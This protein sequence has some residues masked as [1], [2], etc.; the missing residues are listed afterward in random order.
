MTTGKHIADGDHSS[1]KPDGAGSVPHA[2]ALGY[3]ARVFL[4]MHAQLEEE[5]LNREVCHPIRRRFWGLLPCRIYDPR[6]G[7]QLL[8]QY[9]H[10][11]EQELARILEKHSVAYWLHLYRR[12]APEPIGADKQP[13]TVGL[14]RATLEAAVQKY[15]RFEPCDAVGVTGD[16]SIG[17]VLGG[18]L[19]EPQFR[20]ERELLERGR[21]L[22]LTKFAT[23]DLREF[24]DAERLAYE[25]WR[26][27]AMLR[28]V[29]KGAAIAVTDS[30]DRVI[31]LRSPEL[32]RLVRV[33]D[34]R[35]GRWQRPTASATGVVF[36][37]IAMSDDKPGIEFLPTYNL[38]RI[39]LSEYEGLFRKLCGLTIT[40][41]A[42]SNFIWFP[43]N[44]REYRDAHAAFSEAFTH[45]HRVDLDLL[46]MILTALCQR[47]WFAWRHTETRLLR[48]EAVLRRWQRAYDG[49]YT[50][51]FIR[52]EI[53][54][55]IPVAAQRLGYREGQINQ[56]QLDAAFGFLELDHAKRQYIDL[57]YP[58]PHHSF[59]PY[60]SEHLFLDYAWIDRRLYDLFLGVQVD[61][62]NFKGDTLERVVR[63]GTSVLPKRACTARD[64]GSRQ[65]DASFAL[66]NRLVI[67]ECRVVWRSVAFDRGDPRAI[68]YRNKMIDKLLADVDAKAH[69]LATRPVG[70]NYDISRFVD[71]L[72]VGVTPFAEYIPS[73]DPRYWLND[74]LPR[75]LTPSELK[76]ALEDGTLAGA[77]T[78]V[79]ATRQAT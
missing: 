26:S 28:I 69:W 77:S 30:D 27:S 68:G 38:G 45:K 49:P 36:D 58:G 41:P 48:A 24:Y 75:V 61:D 44:L 12:L 64:G 67:V 62:Q 17:E 21:Q 33:Y 3:Y 25:V 55:F 76:L 5:G 39:A 70:T 7:R 1:E 43:F 56:D 79:V 72:P 46:V 60:G 2:L 22:V 37:P 11:V 73:L 14:V 51:E 19:M 6:E 15:A 78:N 47:V 20:A 32:N 50:R 53:D 4:L 29:G 54:A 59:L 71:I 34:D 10:T 18:I 23:T 65:V 35:W 66:G 13:T 74:E 57:A 40:G 63:E 16:V 31:D 8:L 52:D 42:A 9:L